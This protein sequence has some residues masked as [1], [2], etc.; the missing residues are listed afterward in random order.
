MSGQKV[1]IYEGFSI[2]MIAH[3]SGVYAL[4]GSLNARVKSLEIAT[5][6][7]MCRHARSA[8]LL[9]LPVTAGEGF[10]WATS[11]ST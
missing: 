5:R 2:Q 1:E 10:I 9:L 6:W 11:I 3:L 4:N 7:I 8:A